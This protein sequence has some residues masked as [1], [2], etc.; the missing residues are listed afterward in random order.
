MKKII[1]LAASFL[2]L[3]SGLLIQTGF[4]FQ[5]VFD[6]EISVG[7]EQIGKFKIHLKDNKMRVE[8]LGGPVRAILIR[9]SDGLF[10]YLPDRNVAARMTQASHANLADDIPNYMDYLKENN[11][12]KLGSETVNGYPC[13]IYEFFEPISRGKSKAWVWT[14]K[15]FPVKIE[16]DTP[17]GLTIVTF[18]NIQ[19][20]TEID[21]ELF[22][23]PSSVQIIDWEER[24]QMGTPV[25]APA[26]EVQSRR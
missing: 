19:L 15:N 11:A 23:V 22:K 1:L 7:G 21:D 16:V 12:S 10:N 3:M 17:Q 5:A 9:N 24:Q 18:A 25:G 20:D 4:A 8:S 2:F 14:G 6:Q 26:G 13:D